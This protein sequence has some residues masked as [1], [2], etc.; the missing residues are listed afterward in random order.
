MVSLQTAITSRTKVAARVSSLNQAAT[1]IN[2]LDLLYVSDRID[3]EKRLLPF[4]SRYPTQSHH[5]TKP[6][7]AR[8]LCSGNIDPDNAWKC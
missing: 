1:T 4:T 6:P 3:A 7:T 8:T 2:D 5:K